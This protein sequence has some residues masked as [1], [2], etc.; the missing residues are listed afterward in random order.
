[1]DGQKDMKDWEDGMW[2]RREG[3]SAGEKRE[4]GRMG[5][6]RRGWNMGRKT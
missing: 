1:M 2:E 3:W 6:G 4:G 5:R